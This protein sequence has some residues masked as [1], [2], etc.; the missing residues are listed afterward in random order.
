MSD[1]QAIKEGETHRGG[2]PGKFLS[3]DHTP[4]PPLCQ[5]D[6]KIVSGFSC[7]WV[8]SEAYISLMVT[9]PLVSPFFQSTKNLQCP[10]SFVILK[11]QAKARILRIIHYL[12]PYPY[13]HNQGQREDT[14][15]P[16]L[17]FVFSERALFHLSYSTLN[18]SENAFCPPYFTP[19][20]HLVE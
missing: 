17:M 11:S 3:T 8:A 9:V 16:F 6:L 19:Y 2:R 20:P 12:S 7:A 5:G 10:D 15:S 1:L 14:T 4:P 13:H 18:S